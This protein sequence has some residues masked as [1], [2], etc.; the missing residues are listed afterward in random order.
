M[1]KANYMVFQ[2]G[3]HGSLKTEFKKGTQYGYKKGHIPT[4]IFKKGYHSPTEFKKGNK[5]G[6]R[7]GELR[8]IEC[9]RTGGKK[10]IPRLQEYNKSQEHQ[11]KAGKIAG[12]KNVESG[13]IQRLA[14][15]G[16]G[17]RNMV[18]SGKIFDIHKYS[19]VRHNDH[20][21]RSKSELKYCISLQELYDSSLLHA[22]IRFKSIEIDWIFGANRKDP[23]TW[24]KIIEY[25]VPRT[26]EGETKESYTLQRISKIRSLG[27]TCPIEVVCE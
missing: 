8:T 1:V 19:F 9:G 16:M 13:Y 21:H 22:N 12:M 17:G 18:D 20:F 11:R 24:Q 3:Q 23:T 14:K 10:N 2:K 15:S 6:F 27:I 26:W 4:H 25:H 5:F 7:K